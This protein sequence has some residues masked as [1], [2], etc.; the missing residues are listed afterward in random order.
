MVAPVISAP[1]PADAEAWFDFIVAQQAETY[2]G[3][4]PDDFVARQSVYRQEWV[5]GLA[6]SFAAPGSA[7]RVVAKLDGAI[8]GA[9]SVVDGPQDWEIGAGLVPAPAGRELERL[10]VAPEW[11]GRGLGAQLLELV[12]DGRDL[13]LWLIDGNERARAFYRRRGFV[14]L[15]ESLRTSE[16]WGGVAMHRMVRRAPVA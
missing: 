5:P 11:H 2:A 10:Y 15:P 9:A 4:V 6:A 12:D 14:D 8:V 3:I 1:E 13:Y 16:S 7:W